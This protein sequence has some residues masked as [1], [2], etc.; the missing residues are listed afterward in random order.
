[1][2]LGYFLRADKTDKRCLS[3]KEKKNKRS[4]KSGKT[5]QKAEEIMEAENGPMGIHVSFR[6]SHEETN[7][8]RQA[9]CRT[10]DATEGNKIRNERCADC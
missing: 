4:R 9:G 5:R 7:I 2:L 6:L 10:G 1:M 3:K 8:S